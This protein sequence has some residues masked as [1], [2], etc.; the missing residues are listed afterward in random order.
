MGCTH[1]ETGATPWST[2]MRHQITRPD[3]LY[4]HPV[5]AAI[6][7]LTGMQGSKHGVHEGGKLPLR[8]NLLRLGLG[9]GLWLGLGLGKAPTACEPIETE[10]L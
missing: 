8:V 7:Q 10:G 1:V 9:I 5:C 3:V 6:A 4:G 2:G